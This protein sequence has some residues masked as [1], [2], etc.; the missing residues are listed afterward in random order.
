MIVPNPA[1]IEDI[2]ERSDG[3]HG[4]PFGDFPDPSAAYEQQVVYPVTLIGVPVIDFLAYA[5]QA[6]GEED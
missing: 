4:C 1:Y 2:K 3:V 6:Y 5:Y